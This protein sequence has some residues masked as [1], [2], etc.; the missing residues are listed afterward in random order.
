[1]ARPLSDIEPLRPLLGY[2]PLAVASDI[3][4]TLAPIVPDPAAARVPPSLRRLLASL[5][6]LG[7]R[8]VLITGR[9][10]EVARRMV[11]LEGAAYAAN[12]GLTLWLDGREETPAAVEPYLALARQAAAELSRLAPRGVEVEEKGPLLALHYRRSPQPEAARR[13]VL[14]AVAASPAARR[15][16]VQEGR[17]V[18]ELRPP[19]P[20]DKGTALEE[21]VRRLGLEAFLCLGDDRTDADM[22]RAAVRLRGAGLAN[23]TVAVRSEETPPELLEAADYWVEGVEGVEGLLGG[24]LT[25]LRG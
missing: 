19:L 7:V 17:M 5:C 16:R 23:A 1:M 6:G 11:G 21:M 10:L 22:F 9:S 14:A 20:V 8:I 4:G 12:H 25:A 13:A 18:V 15:F 24:L 3:D 2:R